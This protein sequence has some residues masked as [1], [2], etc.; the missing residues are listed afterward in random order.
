MRESHLS[1]KNLLLGAMLCCTG[2]VSWGVPSLTGYDLVFADEFNGTALD[3]RVWN[4]ELNGNGGG[5]NEL[6]YYLAD[7]VRVADGNLV[8]TAR[9]QNYE[10]RS[11]TSGRINTMGKMAFEHGILQA[12]IKLPKTA[13]GLWPAFWLMGND[14]DSGTSWPY[15][16]EMDVLEAGGAQGIAAGTQERFFISALHWGPYVDGGHPMY[17]SNTTADYSIQD[18]QFHVFT[19]EWDEQKIAMYLDDAADPYFVVNIDEKTQQNSPGNYFHKRFFVLLNMAVGGS[20][21][22]IF[23]VNGITALNNGDQSMSVDYLRVY[24]KSDQKNYLSPDGSEGDDEPEVEEDTTTQLGAFGS[25]SLDEDGHSTFD[26]ENST[27]FVVIGASQGVIDQMGDKIRANYSVDEQDNFLYLWEGTYV[28]VPSEGVNSFGLDEGYASFVVQSKGWSGLGYASTGSAGPGKDLSMLEEEGYILHFAMRGTD[29]LMHTGHGIEVGNAKFAIG[30]SAFNNNGNAYPALGDFKRDGR[31]C[32]FDIPLSV[33]KTLS[34]TL[35]NNIGAVKDNAFVVLSGGVAG[36]Q[37]QF[38]NVFFYKNP[39][40][41]TDPTIEDN[42]TVIGEYAKLS[43]DEQGNSTF[44]FADGYDY[45]VIGAS[46]GVMDQMGDRIRAD[47]SVDMVNNCLWVWDDTYVGV[48]SEGV[49]SFGLDEQYNRFVVTNVGWSGLG[50]ASQNQG[51]DLSML[52]DSYYLHFAMKGDDVLR[53]DCHTVGVGSSEFVIGNTTSG[54]VILGDYRRDGKWYSF[55][56]PFSDLKALS[57]APFEADGGPT[58]YMGNVLKFLSGGASG[59]ELQFDNVFFYKRHSDEGQQHEGDPE[60]GK[61]GSLALDEEGNPTFDLAAHADYVLISLGAEEA[62]QIQDLTVA[63]YRVDDVNNFLY[64]WDQTY[65]PAQSEGVNSFGFEEE[66]TSL[67]VVNP[68][69]SGMGFASTGG[70][71]VGKDMS[72]LDDSYYL[73]FAMRGTDEEHVPHAIQVGNAKFA[74]GTRVFVDGNTI[75][76]LL[77]DFRRDGQWYNFDIP[78]SE[79]QKRANP[80]YSNADNVLSNVFAILS[81]GNV[82]L[83]VNLDA[84]FFYRNPQQTFPK[85]DVNGDGE[86][87]IADITALVNLLLES[88]SNERS[89]VNEDGETNIADLTVLINILLSDD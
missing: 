16:G 29:A 77:G 88:D 51:K 45:V 59:T 18:G 43:L 87:S 47:Y 31:W 10:G 4:V 7:N 8:I 67:N 11:F 6:Q 89:D 52:D 73:H 21:P 44:D 22:G 81:G 54:P 24:Q 62:R 37:L 14:M 69:W 36:A 65:A 27:D 53:H 66:Y 25:L 32:S 82:G 9:K 57:G 68:S 40:V 58:A 72:M 41:D 83:N 79:L 56:I 78:F 17:S 23:D 26:F 19:L 42:T 80:V 35:Y 50:F 85:G 3:T 46:Q 33:L 13:N 71:G 76:S 5:N 61:Y 48:P 39:N 55:D 34:P 84:V 12:S 63:D 86:V 30:A 49:N 20:I 75:Y 28:S 2:L 74:L 38:D 64:L 60:L 1:I 15:C 70:T